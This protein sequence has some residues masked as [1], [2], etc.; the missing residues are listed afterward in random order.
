MFTYLKTKD[1]SCS[2]YVLYMKNLVSSSV[3]II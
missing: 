3:T 1:Y 2:V